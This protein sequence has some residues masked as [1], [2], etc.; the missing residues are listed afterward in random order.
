MNSYVRNLNRIEFLITFA[1]T[2]R[3]KHC[4]EG[5]HTQRGESIDGDAAVRAVSELCQHFH[6]KSLMTFGGEPLLY[7]DTVCNIHAAAREGGIPVRQL[8]TNGFFSRDG[9]RIKEAAGR[10]AQS[11]VNN[12][13]LSVDAFHQETIPL[14]PVKQFAEAAKA[15]GI[16]IRAHPAWLVHKDAE[17]PYNR[18]TLEILKEF[19][20]MGIRA[21]EGNIIFPAG[22]ALKNLREYFDMSEKRSNP[23]IED[24]KDIRSICISPDGG[25]LGGNIRQTGI[26]D[27]LEQYRPEA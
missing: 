23:Y 6:I 14:A 3:C 16:P 19:E 11:G 15:A 24:P 25:V 9:D 17:N 13:L 1:C 21:S 4:S 12:L 10:L 2:G 7:V 8:I 22:N 26:P 20:R 27:I 18:Q 5:E